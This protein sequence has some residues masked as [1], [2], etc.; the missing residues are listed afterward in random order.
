LDTNDSKNTEVPPIPPKLRKLYEAAKKL[1]A[2]RLRLEM[3]Q[4]TAWALTPTATPT[5]RPTVPPLPW[6]DRQ[7]AD[8]GEIA[9]VQRR[10]EEDARREVEENLLGE[11]GDGADPD[12]V[13]SPG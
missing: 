12:T 8:H 9:E 6:Q 4:N 13:G 2:T 10:A 5:P 3:W 7:D 11:D 1:A